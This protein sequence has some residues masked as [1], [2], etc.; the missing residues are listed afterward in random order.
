MELQA[1]HGHVPKTLVPEAVGPKEL[2]REEVLRSLSQ[3]SNRKLIYIVG[4]FGR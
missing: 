2:K 4:S 3:D 1:W